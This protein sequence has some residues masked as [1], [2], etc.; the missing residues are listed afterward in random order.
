M[1]RQN[2]T[3]EKGQYG[4]SEEVTY[5]CKLDFLVHFGHLRHH[6]F[7]LVTGLVPLSPKQQGDALISG[8]LF[9]LLKLF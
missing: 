8:T 1:L 3:K 9:E 2:Y 7:D 6:I 4:Y 5:P